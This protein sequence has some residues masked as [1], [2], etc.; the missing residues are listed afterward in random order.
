[1][2]KLIYLMVLSFSII[3]YS[4][5]ESSAKKQKTDIPDLSKNKIEV[6]YFH[7]EHRCQTCLDIEKNTKYTL[8]TYFPE[9]LKEGE[10]TFR[11]FNVD[12]KENYAKSEEYEAFGSALFLNVIRNGTS[13]KINLTDFAFLNSSNKEKFTRDLKA[14]INK[15]L[16]NL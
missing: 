13:K 5:G 4:C 11:T 7:A 3:F 8:E 14:E 12:K 10:I 16:K 2:K 1:M 15:E 6:I 9:Q